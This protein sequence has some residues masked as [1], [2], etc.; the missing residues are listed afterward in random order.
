[1]ELVLERQFHSL[2]LAPPFSESIDSNTKSVK[3]SLTN[4][5]GSLQ[6]SEIQ[7]HNMPMK[8]DRKVDYIRPKSVV[9]PLDPTIINFSRRQESDMEESTRRRQFQKHRYKHLRNSEAMTTK[10]WLNS[11]DLKGHKVVLKD[12]ER[13]ERERR[14]VNDAN[15]I[16]RKKPIQKR[17]PKE[18]KTFYAGSNPAHLGPGSYE[19][20]CA[21]TE[22]NVSNLSGAAFRDTRR[23]S[24]YDNEPDSEGLQS[25]LNTRNVF[26]RQSCESTICHESRTSKHINPRVVSFSRSKATRFKPKELT[27]ER[28][29]EKMAELEKRQGVGEGAMDYTWGVLD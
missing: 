27:T 26:S 7:F 13:R 21:L 8:V 9:K 25:D 16:F 10:Y 6:H 4:L 2:P 12:Q 1:M 3:H 23:R 28:F 18:G 5:K 22:E 19:T 15:D 11:V 24:S 20:Y 17:K 14:I 29:V